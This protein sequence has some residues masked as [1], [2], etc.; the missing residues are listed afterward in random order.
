MTWTSPTLADTGERMELFILS[1]PMLT[2]YNPETGEKRWELEIMGGEIAPSPT[3]AN[4]LVYVGNEYPRLAAV[5]VKTRQMVWE[6]EDDVPDIPSP[7]AVGDLLFVAASASPLFCLDARTGERLWQQDFDDEFYASPVAA[8]GLVYFQDMTGTMQIFKAA[9]RYESVGT[10]RLGEKSTC[11]PAFVN[12][13]I[14]IR[15]FKHLFCI[16]QQD[17]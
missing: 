9:R 15:G 10:G 7:L 11:T 16:E 14:Y 13:R 5:D 3:Y 17:E 4:G 2:S 6:N 1:D 12:G 8:D